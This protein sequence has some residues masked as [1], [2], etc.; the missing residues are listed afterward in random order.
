[1]SS[2]EKGTETSKPQKNSYNSNTKNKVYKKQ[3]QNT[4]KK[5][6]NKNLKKNNGFSVIRGNKGEIQKKKLVALCVTLVVILS[7]LIFTLTSPTGPIERITNGL[8]TMGSGD[9]S[10]ALSGTKTISFQSKNNKAYV[11]T[12]SHL[13]GYTLSGKN[14]LQV[15]HNFSNP[16]L[17]VSEERTLIY[18]RESNKFIVA[19]NSGI[20]FEENLENSI[21]CGDISYNGSVAFACESASYSAQILVFNNNMKQ[22]YTWYLADGLVS[23]IAVSNNGKYVAVAVLKVQN[24]V[25]LTQIYCLKTDEKEPIF[26]KELNDETVL[27]I[28]SVSSSKFAYTSNKKVSFL[29]W[30]T[31]EEVNKNN[32]NAPSYFSNVSN[33]YLALYGETNHSDIVLFN[34]SG[35]VKH[36]FEFNGIIDDVSVFDKYVF[37]LSGNKVT[38][39]DFYDSKK[40]TI[41]LDGKVD[42]I[43]GIKEGVLT[44][45]NVNMKVVNIKNN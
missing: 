41:N 8:E 16:V 15:Q 35:E 18:N 7:V 39:F 23:D 20:V 34:S 2:N 45:N 30:K 9:F 32:F 22:Y 12:N 38:F 36:Q 44:L 29:E 5:N 31:G 37:I 19:N 13:C 11:L 1:M 14:F 42:S 4:T 25:F 3:P 6:Q 24:G 28:E 40:E 17:D 26:I 27:N 10:D 43:L 33:Y 21:Y